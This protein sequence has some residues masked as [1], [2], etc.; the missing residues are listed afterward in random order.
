MPSHHLSTRSEPTA[1]TLI[2]DLHCL[3]IDVQTTGASP[4]HGAM[5]EIGWRNYMWGDDLK[6]LTSSSTERVSMLVRPP[7]GA[8]IPKTVSKLTGLSREHLKSAMAPAEVAERLWAHLAYVYER[9]AA[10]EPWVWVAHSARFERSFVRPLLLAHP[11]EDTRL[12]DHCQL[13]DL[14]ELVDALPWVCTHAIAQRRLPT[15]PRRT[16]SAMNGY[17]E[18]ST[19]SYKRVEAHLDATARIWEGLMDL[20][21]QAD[22]QLW[23]DLKYD[24]MTPTR[25]QK[26]KP[27]LSPERRLSAPQLPGVYQLLNR[28]GEPIYVGVAGDL[29][30]RI[31]Q[32]FRG[33]KGHDER[34]LELI[35]LVEDVRWTTTS[36]HLEALI[37]E[38][39]EIKRLTPPYN[40]ALTQTDPPIYLEP[41]D[42]L[43]PKAPRPLIDSR[44]DL[45][46]PCLR[47]YVLSALEVMGR[48]SHGDYTQIHQ[49]GWPAASVELWRQS[50]E[51]LSAT[52][53]LEE[54]AQARRLTWMS[55][56]SLARHLE[57][58]S[59]KSA[60]Q[61]A[62][63][64]IQLQETDD[65]V[66]GV[67][68]HAHFSELWGGTLGAR[69]VDL[70]AALSEL[71][72]DAEG[73]S[74][75]AAGELIWLADQ[76][77]GV[78]NWRVMT[79][80]EATLT[81][82][83]HLGAPP[84]GAQPLTR[85]RLSDYVSPTLRTRRAYDEA[86][87]IW[88]FLQRA[89]L[90]GARLFWRPRGSVGPH[91]SLEQIIARSSA[92]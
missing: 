42:H 12:A 32:H 80:G 18:G 55:W 26:F 35:T 24:L 59:V 78:S 79:L 11:P 21:A 8:R 82:S 90:R 72:Y 36:S 77:G 9:V 58:K 54:H 66:E 76:G 14:A 25:R 64:E 73:V 45:I 29:K 63:S 51:A 44:D 15:A 69:C 34:H 1:D 84:A 19:I 88:R 83:Q 62:G 53:A 41:D 68:T 67:V 16:L 40:R 87:I 48:A 71:I 31:N 3:L 10:G 92:T 70:I 50:A 49:G 37:L 60:E 47:D 74:M 86:R 52:I 56:I 4:K 38:N 65:P 28:R 61:S 6:D 2:R 20:N 33:Q 46:G 57:L 23:A 17:F 81:P 43:I 7:R 13:D 91:E 27:A 75:C 85:D 30:K 39:R 22:I 89:H 5:I